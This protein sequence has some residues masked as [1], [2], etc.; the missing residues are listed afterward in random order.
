MIG[1]T[2][3]FTTPKTIPLKVNTLEGLLGNT[4][5][6][7]KKKSSKKKSSGSSKSSGSAGPQYTD[8]EIIQ[9]HT[10]NLY[11]AY[12]P[13]KIVYEQQSEETLKN[14]IIGWLRP[15]Y[16]AMIRRRQEQ[17]KTYHA[18][19][20]ADAVSR[21][22]GASTYVT[23][24]KSRQK[25][26][27]AEDILQV[28]EN[29][30][31]K[32]AQYLSEAL[33]QERSRAFE[34]QVKNVELS[35]EAYMKAYGA[36]LQLFTGYKSGDPANIVTST[37]NLK[38]LSDCEAYVKGLTG[39]Q[40]KRLYDGSDGLSLVQRNQMISNIGAANFLYLQQTYPG[41]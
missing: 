38:S 40:R 35:H 34:A 23:D 29:Y 32:L 1:S 16:D 6:S 33:E 3:L 31:A 10:A 12:A 21:G 37:T 18:E 17:T 20:D 25:E 41:A 8:Q 26:Q 9:A 28:E 24:V 15:A 5:S 39:E 27:E 4:N 7:K 11:S 36:A 30:G 19:L 14:S 2:L 22:M 13:Q